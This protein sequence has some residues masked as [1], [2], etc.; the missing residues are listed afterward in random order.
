MKCAG[1]LRPFGFLALFF[2]FLLLAI[3]LLSMLFYINA[4][5]AVPVIA[6][7]NPIDSFCLGTAEKAQVKT[8]PLSNS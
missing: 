6:S 4:L 8:T 7:S 5:G 1:G 2:L 3:A